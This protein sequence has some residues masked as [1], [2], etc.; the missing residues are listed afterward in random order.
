M[1]RLDDALREALR[2]EDPPSGFAARAMARIEAAPQRT[3]V[4][5]GLQGLFGWRRWRWAAALA[6]VVLAVGAG[7]YGIEM[8]RRAEGE[9]ARDQVM[10]ALRITGGKLR[11]AQAMVQRVEYAPRER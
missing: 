6:G 2:R 9:R 3:S 11:L 7:E 10:L 8:Q 1:S 4:W 5:A